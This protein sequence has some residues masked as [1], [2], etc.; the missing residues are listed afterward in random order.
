MSEN[1]AVMQAPPG[2]A[3]SADPRPEILNVRDEPS[4]EEA[5]NKA[6]DETQAA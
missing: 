2:P 1:S 5:G 3:A 4:A 6:G